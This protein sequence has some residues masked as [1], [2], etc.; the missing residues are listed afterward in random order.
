MAI[1]NCVLFLKYPLY[2]QVF[3]IVNRPLF[4]ISGVFFLPDSVPAPYRDHVLIN[5]LVHII[6]AFRKGFYPEYRAVGRD[7]DYLYGIAFL[8]L[9]AGMLV[10]TLSRKTLRNE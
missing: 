2:K 6:M 1:V 4:L 8:T 7:M 9:F 5:P 3:G 10:F